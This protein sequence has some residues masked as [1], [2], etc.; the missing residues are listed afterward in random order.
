MSPWARGS[1]PIG[2]FYSARLTGTAG[3]LIRRFLLARL[4]QTI[5]PLPVCVVQPS[6][7]T[8]LL[9]TV[10]PAT[11]LSAGLIPA[12]LAAVTLAAVTGLADEKSHP[13]VLRCDKNVV[14]ERPVWQPPGLSK[15]LDNG[16]PFVGD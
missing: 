12:R 11:L 10:V 2:D 5:S 1:I 15:A 6:G 14:E 8:P 4:A 13:A 9:V 7:E 16:R 3:T